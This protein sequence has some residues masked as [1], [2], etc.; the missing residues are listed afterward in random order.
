[1]K[2]SCLV[3]LIGVFLFSGLS[4][5]AK[6]S[7]LYSTRGTGG[8]NDRVAPS[9]VTRSKRTDVASVP[10]ALQSVLSEK[11]GA[12]NTEYRVTRSG[13]GYQAVNGRNRL[14]AT[15]G[16]DGFTVHA[17][18]NKWGLRLTGWGRGRC[19][20]KS[21][22][23]RAVSGTNRVDINRGGLAEW[24]V[25]G[26]LGIEQGWTVANWPH[27]GGN[28]GPLTLVLRQ[29]GDLRAQA[30]SGGKSLAVSTHTGREVLRYVG[31]TAYDKNGRQLPAHFVA[32]K[33]DVR[34]VVDDRSAAYPLRIDPWV[35]AAK[36][37]ASDVAGGN[38]LGTAVAISSDGN[39]VV[40]GAG[41]SALYVFKRPA[42]GWA[43]GTETAKLTASDGAGGNGLGTAVAISSDGATIAAGAWAYESDSGQGA[44][45]VFNE[46]V[47]GWASGTET[48][49][50]TASDGADWAFLGS[51]VAISSDGT[52]IVAGA[53]GA[54]VGGKT[55]QGAVYVF[56]ELV[57]G[58]TS[59]TETAKLTA[60]DGAGGDHLGS[61]V[62]VSSDGATVVAGAEGAAVGDILPALVVINS[63]GPQ[64][65][66]YVFNQPASGWADGTEAAKLTAS[67]GA[68]LD[69]LG[70][71]VAVSS[72]GATAVAGAF[73][74]DAG[75][76]AVYVFKEPP[77]GWA[78]E[79]ETAKLTA[80]AG[81][82][83]L[84]RSVAM[85]PDGATVVTAAED[86]TVGVN[87]YQGAVY[88]FG[89]GSLWQNA[90]GLGNGWMWLSWFSYFNTNGAPWIYHLTLGWLYPYGTSTDNIWFYDPAMNAFW[91]TS[92][93]VYPYV[94]RASDGHWLY[95]SVP[96]QGQSSTPRWFYDF[97]SLGWVNY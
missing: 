16:T 46:P 48:A 75:Q 36:L 94:Y 76:G 57:S 55:Y 65:A 28:Q 44:V 83:F 20:Q 91:W 80:S 7:G 5:A 3:A 25:N 2:K 56:K 90:T 84:G 38:S 17:G 70:H 9:N 8:Q 85:S 89:A 50:L 41:S 59:G 37:T 78:S 68:C 10:S 77:L 61:S 64:G 66:V 23:G 6:D 45:Y 31:L 69:R 19:V 87:N 67:D 30:L 47:S 79:I 39:T 11:L 1:M 35:Q 74:N 12:D 63:C 53:D 40:A 33:E 34:V 81:A 4:F 14:R 13:G 18:S 88:V 82:G 49:K 26:P 32:T 92:A 29:S 71:A 42:S 93:T 62:A 72:D 96:A 97:T 60:S 86:E 15:I 58:W 27:E 51:A 52:T 95:Y 24:W 22:V 43:S 54:T 73:C 21:K